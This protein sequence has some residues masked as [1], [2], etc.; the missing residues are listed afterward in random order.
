MAKKALRYFEVLGSDYAVT[1]GRIPV[2]GNYKH[3]MPLYGDMQQQTA[4]HFFYV[5][6]FV[7][8]YLCLD[9]S[10]FRK[11]FSKT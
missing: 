1:Q 9:V 2:E 10:K 3:C 6:C 11:E 4:E 7:M 5:G 8:H